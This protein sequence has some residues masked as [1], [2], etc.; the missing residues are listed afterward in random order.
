MIFSN[1]IFHS[2]IAPGSNRL[3]LEYDDCNILQV[4][5]RSTE[6]LHPQF[7]DFQMSRIFACGRRFTD[8]Q[9][10]EYVSP[11]GLMVKASD[12]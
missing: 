5:E 10:R 8:F 2:A 3:H 11:R 9:L 6:I 7:W 1:L 4:T 12:F